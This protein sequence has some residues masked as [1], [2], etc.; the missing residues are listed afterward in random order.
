[1]VELI[2]NPDYMGTLRF[3]GSSLYNQRT[4]AVRLV[5]VSRAT[6]GPT[7][8]GTA[9]TSLQVWSICL[10]LK[11][12]DGSRTF[13]RTDNSRLQQTQIV[14]NLKLEVL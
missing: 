9:G 12:S 10:S 6:V 13:N 11:A 14:S 2:S 7:V 1:M 5:P 8:L 4:K 3:S